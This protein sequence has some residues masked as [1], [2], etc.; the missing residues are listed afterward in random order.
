MPPS[1]A[2]TRRNCPFSDTTQS[3]FLDKIRFNPADE[4]YAETSYA[5]L[6]MN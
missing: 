2:Y 3:F 1:I 6:E 4:S 5:S